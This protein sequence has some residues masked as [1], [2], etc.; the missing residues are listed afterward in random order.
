MIRTPYQVGFGMMGL[1]EEV[2]RLPLVPTKP[3]NRATLEKAMAVRG[4][5]QPQKV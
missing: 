4:F 5:L 3:E 1:I 2:Y